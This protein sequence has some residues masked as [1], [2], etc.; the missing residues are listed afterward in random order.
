MTF[1]DEFFQAMANGEKNINNRHLKEKEAEKKRKKKLRKKLNDVLNKY[2]EPLQNALLDYA[3]YGVYNMKYRFIRNDFAGWHKFVEGGYENAH[4]ADLIDN[5]LQYMKIN[6]AIPSY[7]NYV[8]L[9]RS[10]CEVEF[11]WGPVS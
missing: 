4:P 10:K 6:G 9:N 3:E 1:A 11:S 5:M 2:V 7:I 8:F